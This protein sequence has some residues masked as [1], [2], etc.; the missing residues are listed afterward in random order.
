MR[1]RMQYYSRI[2]WAAA[3]ALLLAA[4][5]WAQRGGGGGR[6]GM[7][8]HVAPAPATG[9]PAGPSRPGSGGTRPFP[10]GGFSG[11]PGRGFDGG[12]RDGFRFG[13]RDGFGF[14]DGFF[15]RRFLNSSFFT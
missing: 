3:A 5:A 12:F 13:R 8:G 4:P 9:R 1:L 2:G 10:G 15:R 11:R 14:H 7:S 6:G